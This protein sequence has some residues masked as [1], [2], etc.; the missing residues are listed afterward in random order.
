MQMKYIF[1]G[2]CTTKGKVCNFKL[3]NTVQKLTSVFPLLPLA[4][5]KTSRP[6]SMVFAAF[7]VLM[8]KG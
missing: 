3:I 6:T 2:S 5:T 1:H 7:E 8:I 4:A